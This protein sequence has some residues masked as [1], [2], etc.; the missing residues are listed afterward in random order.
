MLNQRLQI[1]VS[2]EQRRRLESEARRRQTSVAALIREAIDAR[3]EGVTIEERLKALD[4]IGKMSGGPYLSPAELER[5]VAAEREEVLREIRP[6][7]EH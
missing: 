2:S 5:I 4:E 1:L 6:M 7:P 3:Y